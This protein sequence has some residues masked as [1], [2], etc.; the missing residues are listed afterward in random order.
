MNILVT[1]ATG[2]I[3]GR[4]IPRLL[5]A[6]HSVT[7]F[8]RDIKR[9]QQKPWFKNVHVIEGDLADSDLKDF[10]TFDAGYYLIHSIYDST[11]FIQKD[12]R[13]A[14]LFTQRAKNI[15][16]I[17]YLGGLLPKSN[18]ISDHLGSR[19]ETGEILRQYLPVTEFRAGPVIGSGSASFEMVRYLTERIPIMITPKWINN[20][21]QPIGINDVLRYL[22]ASLKLGPQGVI[23]IGSEPISFKDMMLQYAAVKGLRRIIIPLPVLT[24]GLA[25]RWVGLVTPISNKMAVPLIKGVI[26]PIYADTRKAQSYFPDIHPVLY[27]D[28]VKKALNKISRQMVATRWS[29]ALGNR[30]YYTFVDVQGIFQEERSIT[31]NASIKTTLSVIQNIGGSEGWPAWGWAWKLRG[32]ADSLIGGPGLR[33]GRKNNPSLNIGDTI[34]FWRV[35]NLSKDTLLLRAE[36]KLPGNAWLQFKVTPASASSQCRLIQTALFAPWGLW[37]FIY[38]YSMFPAHL[39]IFKSMVKSLAKKAESVEKTQSGTLS[40]P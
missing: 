8:V 35:E 31:V 32:I 28:A 40:K 36:M 20:E 6:G 13:I 7:V 21:V 4:L 25:A 39:F 23:D 37:G 34:D 1:G 9:I 30:P 11:S 26:H 14:L 5:E 3:G 33:R 18:I 10:P 27:K 15:A 38:W 12:P 29:D 24:P 17:I 2:Y 16:H 19:A 22:V